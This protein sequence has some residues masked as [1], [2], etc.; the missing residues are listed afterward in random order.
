[1]DKEHV[2]YIYTIEYYL[3]IKKNEIK[4]F[5]GKWVEVEITMCSEVSQAQKKNQILH[6]FA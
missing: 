6:G 2:V 3:P 5:S 4:S 1:M